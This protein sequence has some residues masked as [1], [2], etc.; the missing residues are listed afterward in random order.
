M[1]GE[2][3]RLWRSLVVIILLLSGLTVIPPAP[4][5]VGQDSIR[6]LPLGDSIT[7]GKSGHATY[8]YFLWH[9]LLDAGHNIDFVGSQDGVSRGQPKYP[10]FDQDHEGHS[11]FTANKVALSVRSW[12]QQASAQIVLIH[13]GT[14]DVIKGQSNGS[15]RRDLAKVIDE[16]RLANPQIQILL[17]EIIP[18][19]GKE[20]VVQ[21]LNVAIRALAQEKNSPSSPVI[22]VDQYAGFDVNTD[23]YDGV[24]PSESGYAKI[25]TRWFDGLQTL[26]GDTSLPTTVML[27]EP[28]SGASLPSG[29]TISVKASVAGDQTI[30]KVVFLADEVPIGEDTSSPYE[31]SWS[32]AS[33]GQITLRADAYEDGGLV[34]PSPTV[35]ITVG[36]SPDSSEVTLVVGN[37]GSLGSGD[38]RVVQRLEMLGFSVALA[39][40]D[41]VTSAVAAGKALVMISASVSSGRIGTTFTGTTVPIIAWEGGLFDDLGMTGKGSLDYGE[42]ASTDQRTTIVIVNSTHPLAAGHSGSIS[43]SDP[44][45]RFMWG[46]PAPTAAR[47][48]TL[49]ND[50]AKFA[51]FGYDSG[52]SMVSGTAPAR[53]VGLFLH[54]ATPAMLTAAGWS[55]FDASVRW[56]TGG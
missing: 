53:R 29:S 43:V 6:I 31:Q 17:A 16:L 28:V 40:D 24:H 3:T 47:V 55:V 14:N 27:T 12:G 19:Q 39:D 25:A 52:A 22:A 8:R 18:I 13:L 56:A 26:L 33:D 4:L 42:T 15:T 46:L 34:V 38:V 44:A 2:G 11:G 10:D 48:A 36:D 35:L 49:E 1:N 7:E 5:A 54:P 32:G 51:V 21:D 9:H 20:A 30:S 50:P 23:L 37:P 45:S 41:G